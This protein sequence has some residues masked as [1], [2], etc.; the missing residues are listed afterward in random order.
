MAMKNDDEL[1]DF[2]TGYPIFRQTQ[3]L[4]LFEGN[5]CLNHP[6]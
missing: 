4:E 1:V 2:G 6:T 5:I 3:I